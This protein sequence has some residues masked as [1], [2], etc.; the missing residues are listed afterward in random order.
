MSRKVK[1]TEQK[2][3]LDVVHVSHE[4]ENHTQWVRTLTSIVWEACTNDVWIQLPVN[5]LGKAT[6]NFSLLN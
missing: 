5:E 6:T 2:V 4:D 3:V 1:K